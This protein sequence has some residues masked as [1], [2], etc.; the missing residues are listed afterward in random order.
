MTIKNTLVTGQIF[1]KI[2]YYTEAT[3]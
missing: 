3:E 1:Y 2:C